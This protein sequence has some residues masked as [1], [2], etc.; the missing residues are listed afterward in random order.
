MDQIQGKIDSNSTVEEGLATVSNQT[1]DEEWHQFIQQEVEKQTKVGGNEESRKEVILSSLIEKI[2]VEDLIESTVKMIKEK[3]EAE[4]KR[5]KKNKNTNKQTETVEKMKENE[6][7]NKQ[8]ETVEKIMQIKNENTKKQTETTDK[9]MKKH[10][11]YKS[12]QKKR[13]RELY[14]QIYG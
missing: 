14:R 6:N 1:N 13:R 7:T 10:G 5:K 11:T 4:I 2:P 9:T 3:I 12:R 8:T